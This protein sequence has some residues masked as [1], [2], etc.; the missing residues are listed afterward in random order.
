MKLCAICLGL[1]CVACVAGDGD[2]A[3]AQALEVTP[4]IGYETSGSYPLENPTT[5]EA[6]RADAAKMY[7]AFVDYSVA[8]NVEVELEWAH[9]PTTYSAQDAL[10]G[11]YSQAFA[12]SIN[13][14]QLGAL[15]YLRDRGNA[16][17]PYVAGSIG[18]THDSNSGDNPGRTAIGFGL[19]GGVTRALSTHFGL[20]ADVRWMPTFGSDEMSSA[21]DDFGN[22]YPTTFHH[23]LQRF[24]IAIGLVVRP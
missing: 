20:R 6:F 13:Q 8:G 16:W 14:Y 4:F 2:P 5:V 7:G 12:T 22:C 10:T 1:S 3:T 19:G 21:C 15:Y 11:Q 18:F 24:D 9:N 23:F 17:R